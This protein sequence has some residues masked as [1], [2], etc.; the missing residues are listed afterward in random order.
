MKGR[1]M[2]IG[3]SGLWVCLVLLVTGQAG[4]AQTQLRISAYDRDDFRGTIQLATDAKSL[5]EVTYKGNDADVQLPVIELPASVRELRLTGTLRWTHF[6]AGMQT[7]HVQQVLPV[8]DLSPLVTPLRDKHSPWHERLG[9]MQAAQQ[10]FEQ[11]HPELI[12]ETAFEWKPGKRCTA[13]EVAAAEQRLGFELPAEHHELLTSAGAWTLNESFVTSPADLQ[14]ADQQLVRL[15]DTPASNVTTLSAATR[16]I[17]RDS[18]IL[19]TQVGD[20]YAGLLYRPSRGATPE[21]WYW[22]SQ[23]GLDSPKL[24]KNS[25]GSVRNYS[26]VLLWLFSQEAFV[27]YEST[28]AQV[29]FVDRSAPGPLTYKMFPNFSP[30]EFGFEIRLQWDR[31]E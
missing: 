18:V 31:F 7:S 23:D 14:R 13:A 12:E 5:T 22:L 17:L 30:Q 24:L 3:G 28:G 10:Q 20:G 9:R 29:L 15:W 25:D 2:S 6:A 1:A 19:Y 16:S 11:R 4:F 27:G 8:V 21:A 26:Q